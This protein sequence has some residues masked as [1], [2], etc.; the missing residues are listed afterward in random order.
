MGRYDVYA[1]P[2]QGGTGYVLDVPADLLQDLGTRIVVPR[3]PP[4]VALKPARA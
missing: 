3:L 2:G 1:A 4:D